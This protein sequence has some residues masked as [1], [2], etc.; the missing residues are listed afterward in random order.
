MN[1]DVCA[2]DPS[3]AALH[4]AVWRL[5]PLDPVAVPEGWQRWAEAWAALREGAPEAS[6]ERAANVERFAMERGEAGLLIEAACLR[7]LAEASCGR[8]EA[9]THHARR[10]SRMARTESIPTQE[11]S[12]A[13]VLARMRR[14]A[15]FPHLAK[16]ILRSVERYASP[17]FRAWL[18]WERVVSGVRLEGTASGPLSRASVMLEQAFDAVARGE[19]MPALDVPIERPLFEEL[20]AIRVACTGEV[21][22]GTSHE[23]EAWVRGR[24]DAIP[25]LIH[26]L[27]S[28]PGEELVDACAVVADPGRP[29]RRVASL[30]SGVHMHGRAVLPRTRRKDGRRESMVA[31]LALAAEPVSEG[32]LFTRV[33]GFAY[34]AGRHAGP[35]GVALHRARKYVAPAG[36]I[37]QRDG[38]VRLLLERG[39]V[40]PDPRSRSS[41][42]DRLLCALADGGSSSAKELAEA[43]GRSRRWIQQSLA[44]LVADGACASERRGRAVVYS[45]EDTTFLEPTFARTREPPESAHE[46]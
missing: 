44:E 38:A 11:V 40:V 22:A 41:P 32:A 34:H 43:V 23:L 25:A 10:A 42:H 1:A 13:M 20:A 2:T 17:R 45:V 39:L 18:N 46:S 21:E 33:Y 29:G 9:A 28:R 31:M 15:G 30:A 16:R 7:A 37:E 14:L 24:V 5:D 3:V 8:L 19:A 27:L 6:A 12:A 26:G 35:L 36:R 4:S